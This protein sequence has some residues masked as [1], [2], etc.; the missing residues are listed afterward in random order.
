MANKL[1]FLLSLIFLMQIFAYS[2]DLMAIS[3]IYTTL[4]SLSVNVSYM[5][6]SK[7][8]IDEEIIYYVQKSANA[9]IEAIGDS[10]VKFG[11]A[12]TFR[13]YKSYDPLIFQ[14]EPMEISL[15]RSAVVGYLNPD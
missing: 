10:Y 6:S 14:K 5:I 7:G 3:A 12:L 9:S 4:E 11:E 15:V 1:G 2:G 8:E 13:L